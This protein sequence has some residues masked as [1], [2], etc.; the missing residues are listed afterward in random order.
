MRA[1]AKSGEIFLTATL[2]LME[3]A[4]EAETMRQTL[5]DEVSSLWHANSVDEA[6]KLLSSQKMGCIIIDAAI[7]E[8][9]C[10]G[11]VER[12]ANNPANE[13]A[14]ILVAAEPNDMQGLVECLGRG[15]DD[16]IW[17]NS[18][19]IDLIARIHTAERLYKLRTEVTDLQIIDSL[20]GIHNRRYI[21]R[22]IEREFIRSK[23]YKRPMSCALVEIDDFGTLE[24][25]H[26]TEAAS[27]VLRL[28][29]HLVQE[30]LRKVDEV[31]RF[32]G[33]EFILVLPE[34][35]PAQGIIGLDRLREKLYVV[36]DAVQGQNSPGDT[37]SWKLTLSAGIATYP[38]DGIGS[39]ADLIMSAETALFSAKRQGRGKTIRA[40][41]EE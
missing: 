23:R 28:T 41:F 15:A 14:S 34:T 35:D 12:W 8:E 37:D 31:A 18:R 19:P 10:V 6:E 29:G 32:R 9:D 25:Q 22:V 38:D 40:G 5:E 17:K 11:I 36:A 1:L 21:E 3:S 7:T 30:T 16:F 2:L 27:L 39:M 24:A 20:T 13:A 33:H 4:E 26:G